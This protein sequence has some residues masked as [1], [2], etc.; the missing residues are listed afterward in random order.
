MRRATAANIVDYPD[1]FAAYRASLPADRQP[2]PPR[3]PAPPRAVARTEAPPSAGLVRFF[4]ASYVPDQGPVGGPA[5]RLVI[6]IGT[7]D[8][9]PGQAHEAVHLAT[10]E[11]LADHAP[12]YADYVALFGEEALLPQPFV[13]LVE[14][15]EQEPSFFISC[16]VA[17]TSSIA[18]NALIWAIR[19]SP[20]PAAQSRFGSCRRRSSRAAAGWDTWSI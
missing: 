12:E 20:S 13:P 3:K 16:P 2:L 4:N 15:P 17:S 14:D 7:D 5:E 19:S 10:D 11:D 6:G 9:D 18:P 8:P 1:A